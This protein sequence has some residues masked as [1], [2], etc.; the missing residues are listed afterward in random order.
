LVALSGPETSQPWDHQGITNGLL[1]RV[2]GDAIELRHHSAKECSM[3]SRRYLADSRPQ[4]SFDVRTTAKAEVAMWQCPIS[5]DY[6]AMLCSSAIQPRWPDPRTSSR[7][8]P[9][10]IPTKKIPGTLTGHRVLEGSCGRSARGLTLSFSWL[11]D[12]ICYTS[13]TIVSP[14]T[15][16]VGLGHLCHRDQA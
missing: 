12:P 4:V 3:H 11:R 7:R 14:D 10:A 15:G 16:R 5:R 2:L 8:L 6:R 13:W 9:R 1:H